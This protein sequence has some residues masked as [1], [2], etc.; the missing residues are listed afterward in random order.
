[1]YSACKPPLSGVPPTFITIHHEAREN[2]KVPI[3]TPSNTTREHPFA[4]TGCGNL[5]RMKRTNDAR[6]GEKRPAMEYSST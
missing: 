1:V 3:S 2:L 6:C 4:R 5:C